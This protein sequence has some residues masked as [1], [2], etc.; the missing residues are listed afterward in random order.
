MEK[1]KPELIVISN[2]DY[3]NNLNNK[4]MSL[5]G[6]FKNFRS[7]INSQRKKYGIRPLFLL[8]RR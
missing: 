3:N 4:N 6:G 5:Q 1:R 8:Q 7:Y 2:D